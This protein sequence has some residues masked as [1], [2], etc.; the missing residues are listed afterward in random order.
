MRDSVEQEIKKLR[1][2]QIRHKR[3]GYD[4]HKQER[5]RHAPSIVFQD[6]ICPRL[7]LDQPG[8]II[9]LTKKN[10]QAQKTADRE[11]NKTRKPNDQDSK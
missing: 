11:A 10:K 6:Y 2:K 1:R 7:T 9:I 5:A 4:K 3:S 8:T